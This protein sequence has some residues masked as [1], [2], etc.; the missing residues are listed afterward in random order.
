LAEVLVKLFAL[1]QK[2]ELIIQPQL[3]LLQKTLL[4]IEGLS[5]TMF[6]KIDI[7]AVAHPVLADIVAERYGI[8]RALAELS[9]RVPSWVQNAPEMPRLLFEWLRQSTSGQHQM[10]M[11]SDDL[12]EL[13]R[14]TQRAHQQ[15]VLAILGAGLLVVATLLW[16]WQPDPARWFGIPIPPALSAL[17]GV[18]AFVLAIGRR[19]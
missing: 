15:S 18:W 6:P 8:K 4:N 9:T 13:V 10:R 19:P 17:G 16:L 5:R 1:A 2:H 11:R 14:T 12:K 3:I 7:W